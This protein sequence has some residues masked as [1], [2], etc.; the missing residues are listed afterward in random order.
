MKTIFTI[1]IV[2][3]M[4]VIFSCKRGKEMKT[5]SGF[6]YILYTE[7]NGPK[8]R[9]G[10]YITMTM[11]YKNNNDSV[12]FDSRSNGK[13]IRFRLEKIPFKG[14]FEDGLTYLSTNDSATFYV[15]ADSLYNFLYKLR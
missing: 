5:D 6:K 12:L 4:I 10:N 7:S 3:I 11:V 8:A 2:F 15:P 13:P 14:S 9:I 1:T